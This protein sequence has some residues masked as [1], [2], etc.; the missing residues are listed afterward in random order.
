MSEQV[1]TTFVGLKPDTVKRG[2]IGEI[3]SIIEDAGFKIIGIK[4][5]EADDDRLEQHY[6][7]HIDKD[8]YERLNEYMKQG[9]FV[10][11]AVEGVEAVENLRKM[12]GDT[13]PKDA[14]PATIRGRFSHMSFAHADG[15]GS[16]HKNIVHASATPEE[17]EEELGI[18]FDQDEI[19][20]YS[21]AHEEEVR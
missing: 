10:A 21:H 3:I 15:T 17:A 13:N 16:L 5:V 1:E 6:E 20:D 18:W 8:F 12:V 9:P 14:H 7:E 11:L 4:M 19:F 2:L